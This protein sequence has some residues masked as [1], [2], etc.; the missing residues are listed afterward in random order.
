MAP[1]LI[2][3]ESYTTTVDIWTLGGTVVEMTDDAP[4]FADNSLFTAMLA[5]ALRQG[6]FLFKPD[7][8][9]HIAL[10][11]IRWWACR[12]CSHIFLYRF[13]NILPR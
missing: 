11:T 1:E 8:A 4:S 6:P 12:I 7:E 5:I 9:H 3:W 13:F 10:E 2:L